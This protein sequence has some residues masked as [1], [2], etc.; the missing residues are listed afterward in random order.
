MMYTILRGVVFQDLNFDLEVHFE[1]LSSGVDG[2][3]PYFSE[4]RNILVV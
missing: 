1:G 3:D 2:A 4:N